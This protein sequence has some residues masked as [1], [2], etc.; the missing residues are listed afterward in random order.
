MAEAGPALHLVFTP[1]HVAVIEQM[2]NLSETERCGNFFSL[3]TVFLV[4]WYIWFIC[5]PTH[6]GSR[7]FRNHCLYKSVLVMNNLDSSF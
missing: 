1:S 6:S 7:A 2:Q 5:F 4:L 3:G